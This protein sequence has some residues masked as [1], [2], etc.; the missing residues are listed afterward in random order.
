M[1]T[2]NVNET[3]LIGAL[4]TLKDTFKKFP[5]LFWGFAIVAVGI[6]L[7]LLSDLGMNPW[8]TF[9]QGIALVTGLKFGTVSQLVGLIIIALS[10]FIHL[11][12]GIGT[13]LNMFFIGFLVNLIT[14]SGW[15]PQ[16]DTLA[17]QVVYLLVGTVVFN[18][19][20][21]VYISCG[22]GAGPR[23][24]LLVGL[25]RL[26]G[27]SVSV[28]RP[29]IEITVFAIGVLLGGAYGVGTLVNAFG[30]G[31]ILHRIFECHHFD[32]NTLKQ[33]VITDCFKKG[34]PGPATPSDSIKESHF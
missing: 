19:G 10:L 27:K 4:M 15:L 32:P 29:A 9:H 11:Y 16:P 22:L 12:P 8:G 26:T 13:L 31:Y 20:I 25:V 28:I 23:D 17:L 33:S 6:S 30:G 34:N 7:T 3:L 14:E 5:R 24:G 1:I 21:Y 2:Q 18:Y